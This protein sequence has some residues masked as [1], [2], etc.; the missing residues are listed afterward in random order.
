MRKSEIT[1]ETAVKEFT[2]DERSL[3]RKVGQYPEVIEQAT[4]EFAPHLILLDIRL[5]YLSGIDIIKLLKSNE[6]LRDIPVLVVTGY[7]GKGEELNARSAGANGYLVKPVS[8]KP[9]LENVGD[10]I[11]P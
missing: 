4:K 10:L 8:I 9:L 2:A 11:A 1:P 6:F 5:P 7:V 3:L